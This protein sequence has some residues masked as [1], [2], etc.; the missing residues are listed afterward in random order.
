MSRTFAAIAAAT[1]ILAF[2]RG[3]GAAA[4]D[5][6]HAEGQDLRRRQGHDALHLRQGRRRQVDVQWSV[7]RELACPCWPVMPTSR[8]AT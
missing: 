2:I 3:L 6:R 8:P 4:E 5:G 7:R 1:F